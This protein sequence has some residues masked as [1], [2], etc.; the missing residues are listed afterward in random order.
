LI[1]D[2][3]PLFVDAYLLVDQS[4]SM[5]DL[6]SGSNPPMTRWQAAQDAVTTFMD[7]PRLNGLRPG[8]P[9]M[10]V[11]IQ[12]F[13]LDGIAPQSCKADYKT[14]EV[15]VGV[16]PGN[17]AAVAAAMKKHQPRAFRPT[18]AALTGAIAHMKEWAP[19]QP[20][21]LPV[22]V[23][24]TDGLP[25]ECDPQN[26]TDLAQIARAAFENP[27]QVRTAVVGLDLAA[28]ANLNELASAG[29]TKK[30]FMIDGGDAGAE[31]VDAMLAI[32]TT[33]ES[34]E[35]RLSLPD[36]PTGKMLDTSQ[37]SMTAVGMMGR[38]TV[39]K[40]DTRADCGPNMDEGWFY[41]IPTNPTQIIL[42]S[43]TCVTVGMGALEISFGCK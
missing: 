26:L 24:V 3:R 17:A 32:P 20:A 36:P 4:S 6:L 14:P 38:V 7:D 16:I 34:P 12:F 37:V 22:V 19:K 5:G 1:A 43:G 25:T 33:V 18:A 29:G 8:Y 10:S 28:S 27:P 21:H 39:P 31:F 23:L 11:G 13:P 15:E 41:D 42:C 35:C 2:G 30:A 40:L 9:A